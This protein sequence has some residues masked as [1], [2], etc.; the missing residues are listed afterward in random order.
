LLTPNRFA[1]VIALSQVL[2]VGPDARLRDECNA[3][4]AAALEA[5]P[6]LHYASEFSRAVEEARTRRPTLAIGEMARDL[7]QM[8]TF[9]EELH[10]A[11]PETK[12]IGAFKPEIFGHQHSESTV[13][14]EALRAGVTDF[15][16]RP[17]SAA[18]LGQ[19]LD[20]ISREGSVRAS[21]LGKVVSFLSNKGGVG[22]ST[23]S[24]N[25]AV[26]LARAGYRVLLIDSSLQMGVCAAMLDLRPPLTLVDA[27]REHSRLDETLLGHLAVA[28]ESGLHLLAAPADAVEGAE[29][30]E[31][32]IS[33]VMSL[34]RRAYDYVVV[35]TFP[36]FD[37]VVMAVLDQ[38]DL[39]YVVI[40]NVVP[41]LL[42]AE[43]FLQLLDSVGFSVAKQRLVINRYTSRANLPPSAAA[44]RLERDVDL[45]V[46]F[47]HRLYKAAN[48]GKPF[49][50]TTHRFSR[51]A[52][53]LRDLVE[54]IRKYEAVTP[55][56]A[57]VETAAEATSAGPA[58]E[59]ADHG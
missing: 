42:G 47:D 1:F 39:A 2:I 19:L 56:P 23:L 59:Q 30:T 36:M 51:T 27:A 26:G 40:E 14:I 44:E 58:A 32:T 18:D 25:T 15:L 55:S 10:T 3:A 41:T 37:R 13:L 31:E 12:L 48:L 38:T 4:F 8:R 43:K 9:A 52:R 57:E 20:R 11:S 28:H 5:P 50:A 29:V 24:V 46:P 54:Q 6:V 22:K 35:D 7:R 53:R 21:R 33:R 45:I 16:R 34:A 49:S 17:V